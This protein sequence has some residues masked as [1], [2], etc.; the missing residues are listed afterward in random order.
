MSR[1]KLVAIWLVVALVSPLLLIMMLLQALVGSSDR[2]KSM[3]LAY[4]Q[5]GNALFGGD[6]KVTIS[7]RTGNALI[8]GKRWAKIVTP[9]IDFF[10]GEGHCLANATEHK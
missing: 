3:A 8:A 7:E 6:P 2:A 10:F 1:R 4:D 5:C 9:I